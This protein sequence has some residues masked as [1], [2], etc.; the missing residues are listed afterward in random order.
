MNLSNNKKRHLNCQSPVHIG[1]LKK[2]TQKKDNGERCSAGYWNYRP[3]HHHHLTAA[4][5]AAAVAE[6]PRSSPIFVNGLSSSL[7]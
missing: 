2:K 1:N 7:W 5:A 3:L 4:A 6:E